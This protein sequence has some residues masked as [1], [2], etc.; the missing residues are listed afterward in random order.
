MIVGLRSPQH[1]KIAVLHKSWFDHARNVSITPELRPAGVVLKPYGLFDH[2]TVWEHLQIVKS[3]TPHENHA[4]YL[5][6]WIHLLELTGILCHYPRQLNA[7]QKFKLA[8][9]RSLARNP[10]LLVLEDIFSSLAPTS[11][12]RMQRLFADIRSHLDIP[13]ILSTDDVSEASLIADEICVV[14]H[15]KTHQQGPCNDVIS[16]PI[17]DGVARILTH[18]NLFYGTVIDHLP[19]AKKSVLQWG[20]EILET[21]LF[22]NFRIGT[23]VDWIIP[24]RGIAILRP[25]RPSAIDKDN[26]FSAKVLKLLILG[27]ATEIT[28]SVGK[29]SQPLVFDMPT[30]MIRRLQ[31]EIGGQ[32]SISLPRTH[33]HLMARPQI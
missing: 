26:P 17:S 19:Y 3:V 2:L 21:S 16:R 7:E 9:G 15:R 10:Q 33:I 31:L 23:E 30:Y 11:R 22:D 8:L 4:Q 14:I 27:D 5:S 12:K 25:D 1:G 32:I 6:Q 13:I 24:S 28:V 20:D 29:N 18:R